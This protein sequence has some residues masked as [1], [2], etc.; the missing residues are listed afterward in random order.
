MGWKSGGFRVSCVSSSPVLPLR[1]NHIS[2]MTG[3]DKLFV[4][5]GES[6]LNSLG[7]QFGKLKPHTSSAPFSLQLNV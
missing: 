1:K 7:N 4:S 3:I 2:Y 6:L 5:K